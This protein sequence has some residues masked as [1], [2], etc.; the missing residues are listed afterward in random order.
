[1]ASFGPNFGSTP[2]EHDPQDDAW[3][4]SDP[5]FDRAQHGPQPDDAGDPDRDDAL[6]SVLNLERTASDQD[7][8]RSYRRLA[9]L[10]HPD[11]HRDPAL[12]P[13]ADARFAQV[14]HAY[15]TLSDPHRR[16]I[17]DEL[18]SEGLRTNWD[19]ATRGKT[20]Q[21]LRAEYERMNRDKLEHSL[22]DL[23]RSKGE[24]T[25]VSDARV[26]FLR[27]A[28]LARLGGP[29]KLGAWQRLQSITQRQLFL[30]HSYTT[31]LTP[32][33]ALVATTQVT[34]R[35]GSGAGNMLVKLQHSA[36]QRLSLE[37]GTTLLRPR[38]LTCKATYAPD[39][40]SF[41][42]V[43]VPIR[44]LAAPPKVNLVVGRRVAQDTT[45]TLTLRSGSWALGTW[46]DELLQPYSD[47]TVSV[48]LSHAS[49]WAAEATA[50][51][52]VRQVSLSWARTVLGGFKVG[53]QGVVTN[54]G[55]ASVGISADRR[56]T[57]NCKAGMGLEVAA[58][59][60]MTVKLRFSR[61]GQR[62]TLPVI[63]SSSLDWRLFAGFTIV[64]ALGIVAS[65]QLVLA[66]RRRRQLSGK[67]RELRREHADYIREKRREALDA[68][69]LLA[70][71]VKTRVREEEAKNGLVILEA[72]YGVLEAVDDKVQDEADLR[73][74]DVTVPLQALLPPSLSQ[75]TIP[76]NRSKSTL[77][78]FCDPALG[79][80]KR[81]RVRYRF[82]GAVH[83]AVWGDREAVALPMR[84]HL[85][86]EEGERGR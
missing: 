5:L 55:A 67:L 42:R 11:R 60:A 50:A 18:G 81:L 69:A 66:P 72:T 38:A 1:M 33:T 23:V 40:D 70:E 27:S 35:Q 47:S 49:G 86:Q 32:R 48:G 56:V 65:N 44:T 16:A 53:V 39:A 10:L 26:C 41:L 31:P 52:F 83:E 37:L 62:L 30:R 21:E 9:A 54:V 61:L 78:G 79:E 19:V 29:D 13:A 15:E 45:G 77:L 20:A 46:G 7:I 80:K 68:Q 84:A 8:Q 58:N 25:V 6:Y 51:V 3:Q 64:P 63:I 2:L 73:W 57:D 59:G 14:Q 74:L 4:R 71:H 22:E 82:K 34:A 76:P 43:D 17:Y 36:S 12:K 28:D 85:V 24:L 75:L